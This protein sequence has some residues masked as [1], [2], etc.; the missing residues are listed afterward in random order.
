MFVLKGELARSDCSTDEPSAIDEVFE[1]GG[2]LSG[3]RRFAAVSGRSIPSD[4]LSMAWAVRQ[5]ALSTC[6]V[7]K[8]RWQNLQSCF[9]PIL[10]SP[11]GDVL[12]ETSE[13]RVSL[14]SSRK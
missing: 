6:F 12:N 1:A 14:S 9:A 7:E 3:D 11:R 4:L 5:C 10:P 8:E 13:M 2:V